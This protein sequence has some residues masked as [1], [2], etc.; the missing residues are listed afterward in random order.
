M[1]RSVHQDA[2]ARS[3]A[4]T[5][6]LADRSILVTGGTGSFGS[7]FV[8]RALADGARRVAVFSRDELKQAQLRVSIGPD[9][10]M[11]Y[12]VGDVQR[13]GRVIEAAH[14]CDIVVHAAALKRIEVCAENPGETKLT[15]VDGT[16]N[17]AKACIACGVDRAVF[18]STDKAPLAA[19]CY[20]RSKAFAE[21]IWIGASVIA[22]GMRRPTRFAA[23]RY[24]NV[25]GSRGSVLDTFR[26]QAQ[27][28]QPLTITHANMTRF[29]M[30]IED[31]VDLVCLALSEMRGGEIFVP[32]A[33]SATILN[34]ADAVSLSTVGQRATVTTTGL[35]SAERLHE[36]LIA[37]EE[38]ERTYDAG[39][40]Y[41][42]EPERRSW[43]TID[44]PPYPKVPGG[45][46]YR[47]DT[48]SEQLDADGLKRLV[49]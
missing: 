24:G 1:L 12:F 45:W 23:T 22:A 44:P 16:E 49:A 33:P 30:R 38:A 15:N 31:A 40:H 17:V 10:R 14:G 6:P 20:G 18:L 26:F 7:A 29:W 13:R 39:S 2:V 5:S 43:A 4:R 25:I 27:N 37:P 47:S 8:K 28:G 46:S 3:V 11:R 41:V 36:T 35:R 48:N 9:D 19:T 42:I 32:K 34:F 21:D